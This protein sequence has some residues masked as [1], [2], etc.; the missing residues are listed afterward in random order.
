MPKPVEFVSRRDVLRTCASGAV[1]LSLLGPRP[2]AAQNETVRVAMNLSTYNNLPI[3]LAADKGYFRDA[4][5]DVQIQGFSGSSTA[6]IPIL[7]R[8]DVDIMPLALGPAFFN[9]FSEGFNIRLVA[10]LSS[11][12]AGWNDTTWLVVRQD[13]WDA[14]TIRRPQ[15]LRGKSVD[16]VAAGSPIDFLALNAIQSGGLTLADVQFSEK[17][18]DPPSWLTALRNKAVDVL[19]VPEPFATA[20]EVQGLAHKWI[21]IS[22]VAPWFD[23]GFVAVSAPFARNH[24]AALVRFLRA[25]LRA[26]AD[27]GR[28]NGKW[29]PDLVASLV[30]WTQLPENDIRQIPGP[31]YI[32]DAKIDPASIARQQEFW[33][34]RG[35]IP[36]VVATGPIVDTA[37]LQEAVAGH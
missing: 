1:A 5:L 7:A 18:H 29:T 34:A 25:Y 3:F 31:A 28:G 17:L 30:K 23:E 26:A 24:H 32:G 37:S 2:A 11:H 16:G 33:H 4:G 9:Q 15:D 27:I 6:Q 20:V 36:T 22:N 19:G 35:L 12:R 13:L 21:S 8:G 14:G 10:A